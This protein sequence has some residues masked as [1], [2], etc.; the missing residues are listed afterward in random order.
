MSDAYA[1]TVQTPAKSP[2]VLRPVCRKTVNGTCPRTKELPRWLENCAL[3]CPDGRGW[4]E[5]PCWRFLIYL[6]HVPYFPSPL[7]NWTCVPF[8]HCHLRLVQ[9]Q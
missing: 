7:V 9:I 3:L 6:R 1:A 5:G 4:F 8:D 2:V